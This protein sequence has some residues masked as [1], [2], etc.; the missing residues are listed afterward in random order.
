MSKVL[1]LVNPADS[2]QR[3][4]DSVFEFDYIFSERN[5]MIERI[6]IICFDRYNQKQIGNR[7]DKIVLEF[8]KQYQERMGMPMIF[9]KTKHI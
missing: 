4:H 9:G 7:I 6:K 3:D 8:D 2:V 1:N 5:R